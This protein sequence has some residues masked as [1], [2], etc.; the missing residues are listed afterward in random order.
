VNKVKQL[1]EPN[2]VSQ[3]VLVDNLNVFVFMFLLHL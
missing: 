3:F 2:A 1:L